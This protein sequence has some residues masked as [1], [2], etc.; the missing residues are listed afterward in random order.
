MEAKIQQQ[1]YEDFCSNTPTNSDTASNAAAGTIIKIKSEV[2]V[3][4]IVPY[5]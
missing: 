3:I 2:A 5:I 4:I 1:A